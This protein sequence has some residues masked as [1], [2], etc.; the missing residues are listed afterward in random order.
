MI[1]QSPLHTSKKLI[2]SIISRRTDTGA[3]RGARGP[4]QGRAGQ[5]PGRRATAH[6]VRSLL[7]MPPWGGRRSE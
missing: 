1:L 7:Q 3:P 6:C 5:P 4:H 2:T